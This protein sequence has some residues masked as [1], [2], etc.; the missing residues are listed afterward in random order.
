MPTRPILA[1]SPI[2]QLASNSINRS[3]REQTIPKHLVKEQE[4]P[5]ESNLVEE[6]KFLYFHLN[7]SEVDPHYYSVINKLHTFRE[8]TI[9][10]DT[11]DFVSKLIFK[12]LGIYKDTYWTGDTITFYQMIFT[13]IKT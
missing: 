3:D 7:L 2:P 9:S 13:L 6:H 4:L 12:L 10:F 5:K 11:T 1:S 8:R